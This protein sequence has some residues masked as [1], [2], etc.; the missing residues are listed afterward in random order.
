MRLVRERNMSIA[1]S[2]SMPTPSG[3]QSSYQSNYQPIVQP[4]VQPVNPLVMYN[5]ASVSQTVQPIS[6]NVPSYV[7]PSSQ[8]QNLSY[9]VPPQVSS[10]YTPA[11]AASFHFTQ[12]PLQTYQLNTANLL[13]QNNTPIYSNYQVNNNPVVGD[14]S[15]KSML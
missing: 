9:Q 2:N 6:F 13:N 11:P 14:D 12:Q 7:L 5:M 8:F 3:Y 15:H 4:I 1:V 10:T